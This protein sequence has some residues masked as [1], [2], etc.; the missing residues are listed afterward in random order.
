MVEG[1]CLQSKS[2]R[3]YTRWFESIRTLQT[4]MIKLK[5]CPFCGF[6]PDPEDNDCIYP[7][8]HDQTLWNLNCYETGGGCSAHVLGKTIEEC[9]E[10]WNRRADADK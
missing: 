6:E 8:G 3:K 10:K 1:T 9:V 7:V 4:H 5:S 2:L